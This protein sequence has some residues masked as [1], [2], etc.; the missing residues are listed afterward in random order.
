[1][2]PRFQRRR[3]W[4]FFL[5]SACLVAC[6]QPKEVA[7]AKWN[8][9]AA[10]QYLD[11]RQI[12]WIAWPSSARDH[13]TFCVSCHTVLPYMLSRAALRSALAEQGPS[14]VER[15]IVGNVAER[16]RLWSVIG[17]Y[18]SGDGYE[19][20]KPAESR[21]TEAILNAL[22]LATIDARSGK[23]SDITRTAFKNM[24]ALQL[25]DGNA[26]GA[27]P[28]LDFG[29]QP[30]EATDSQYYGAALAALATGTAP[31]E[32]RSSP[33]IQERVELLVSY[34]NRH[35]AK[36]SLMN[37][38][39]LLWASTKLPG[40]LNSDKQKSIVRELVKGQKADGGWE[41][42]SNA[43][44]ESW[45]IHS[46]ARKLL[47]S[48]WTRQSTESDGYAT[49]LI[50]LVLEEMGM[51]RENPTVNR[52]LVWLSRNQS[53]EDG[54]WYSSSLKK[55]R[56]SSSNIGHFMRDAATAYAVMALSKDSRAI[57]IDAL[58]NNQRQDYWRSAGKNAMGM[59][60]IQ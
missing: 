32:Y 24:W 14:D 2:P 48:D 10:G 54:S 38:A 41:L 7:P 36:Q 13:G 23:L 35:S 44:P 18:Y 21:G 55:D 3:G 26:K 46:A 39:V 52:A 5:A 22:I 12:N 53:P 59:A 15:K 9:K 27:W 16:V 4:A 40:L 11:Q 50:T 30:W 19:S 49:G 20:A 43:W 57:G 17:P 25:S 33:D 58:A 6:S 42:S 47:R 31:E 34:L 28:W 60:P 1:M 45:S 8:P 29:L 37:R 51:S 56:S